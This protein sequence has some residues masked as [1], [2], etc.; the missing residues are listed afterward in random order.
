VLIVHLG[1]DMLMD[2]SIL[3]GGGVGTNAG[4]LTIDYNAGY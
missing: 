2:L 1:S 4:Y 3:L